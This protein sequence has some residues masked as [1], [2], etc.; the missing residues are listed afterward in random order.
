MTNTILDSVN[1]GHTSVEQY[2]FVPLFN[3]N[4]CI[5]ECYM[6]KTIAIAKQIHQL[7]SA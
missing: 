6:F 2:H 7:R 3:N 5:S 4:G 1:E